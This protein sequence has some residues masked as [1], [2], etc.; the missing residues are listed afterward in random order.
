[1]FVAGTAPDAL[2][3]K[4]K[5]PVEKSTLF[6]EIS[7]PGGDEPMVTVMF[8]LSADPDTVLV[9]E[10]VVLMNTLSPKLFD[11]EPTVMVGGIIA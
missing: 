7:N 6:V 3:A 1:M 10:L 8:S 11:V 2:V 9:Q 4:T 5:G